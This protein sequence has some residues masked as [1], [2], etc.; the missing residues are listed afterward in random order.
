MS[1]SEPVVFE[2]A[3]DRE[4]QTVHN[5]LEALRVL[6]DWWQKVDGPAYKDAIN[7]CIAAVRGERSDEDA[8]HAFIMALSEGDIRVRPLKS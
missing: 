6:D 1:W 5:P 3:R 7:T 8:R 2:P 4:A